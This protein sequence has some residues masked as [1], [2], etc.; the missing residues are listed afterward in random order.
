VLWVY[1][2]FAAYSAAAFSP[3]QPD[4]WLHTWLWMEPIRM[5]L[6][7]TV[8]ISLL[9]SIPCWEKKDIVKISLLIAAAFT[10]VYRFTGI[11][12]SGLSQFMAIRTYWLLFLAITLITYLLCLWRTS[13]RLPRRLFLWSFALLT[14]SASSVIDWEIHTRAAWTN[15]TNFWS[16]ILS[17]ILT[18]WSLDEYLNQYHYPEDD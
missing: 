12:P 17:L 11:G 8:S 3:N 7:T 2:A 18:L 15:N 9:E 6:R 1:F 14:Y 10:L 16:L 13:Q 4:W 5:V